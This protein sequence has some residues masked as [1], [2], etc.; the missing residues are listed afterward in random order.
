MMET[1]RVGDGS[2]EVSATVL[3][4]D[5]E[6]SSTQQFDLDPV[7][8]VNELDDLPNGGCTSK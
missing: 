5:L 8:T 3:D 7:V 4:C 2:T 6:L 1:R